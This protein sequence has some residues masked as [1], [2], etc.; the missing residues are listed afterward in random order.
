M[1]APPLEIAWPSTTNSTFNFHVGQLSGL[2]SKLA[3]QTCQLDF[4]LTKLD[5][6]TAVRPKSDLEVYR[7]L[8]PPGAGCGHLD[9][10]HW[11]IGLR[12]SVASVPKVKRNRSTVSSTLPTIQRISRSMTEMELR[13]LRLDRN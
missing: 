2:Y 9:A 10:L 6:I 8:D 1:S 3:S 4:I 7:H 11:I 12:C 5:S 13:F